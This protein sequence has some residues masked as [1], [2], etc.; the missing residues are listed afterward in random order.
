MKIARQQL[1]AEVGVERAFVV[2]VMIAGDHHDRHCGPRDLGEREAE[3]SL[4]N[5]A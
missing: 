3:C 5:P 4:A 1:A 2:R